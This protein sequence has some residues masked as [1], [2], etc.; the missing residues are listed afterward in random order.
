MPE[1]ERDGVHLY[2]DDRGSGPVLLLS[3]S[4][5]CDGRQWPQ[6][7]ELVDA[8]YRVLNLDNRGHGR[9]GPRHEPCTMWDLA[10][11]LVAVLDDAGVDR[12]VLVGLSIGGFASIRA[13]LRHP[14][15]VAALVLA[16]ASADRAAWP[17]RIK[18]TL[19]SPVAQTSR[20]WPLVMGQVVASLFGATT[21]RRQ[22]ELVA[23]WREIFLGQDP[24]SMIAVLRAFMG[25][26]DVV[27]RLAEITAPTLVVVGEED[28]DPG[29]LAS[30]RLAAR[31][32]GA[33]FEVLPDTGHLSA[34]EQ[35]AAFTACVLEFLRDV[36]PGRT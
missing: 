8:G 16:G 12:A 1:L 36:A 19:L 2:Y 21:R 34:L 6:V 11:D 25:R 7:P 24:E 27:D 17:N 28:E 15:R 3:H 5:F 33:R 9:S 35:P 26:D 14:D 22:P 31:I 13:A 18:A 29:V 23:T 32:A 20:G 30:A 4:W 10:E